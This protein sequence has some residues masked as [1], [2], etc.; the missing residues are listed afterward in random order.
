[1]TRLSMIAQRVCLYSWSLGALSLGLS[2][3]SG[4]SRSP[5]LGSTHYGCGEG[6][7]VIVAEH[8]FCVFTSAREAR[9]VMIAGEEAVAGAEMPPSGGESMTPLCP[10]ATPVLYVYDSLYICS[11][12]SEVS[13]ELIE[14][15]VVR[16]G[17]EYFEAPTAD[18]GTRDMG[19][20]LVSLDASVSSVETSPDNDQ[21]DP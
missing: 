6:D 5:F 20:G 3:T 14:S 11:A 15:V 4:C 12:E 18:Q 16:W 2:F 19:I 21:A 7:R 17:Q 1:M 8:L 10:E 9:P 13:A